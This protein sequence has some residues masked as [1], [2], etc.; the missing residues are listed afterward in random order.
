MARLGIP[1][2]LAERVIG[3]TQDRLIATYDRH[4]YLAEKR[5]ALDKLAGSI[6]RIVAQRPRLESS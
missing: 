5:A 6:L 4:D 1:Q 3:H 2:E